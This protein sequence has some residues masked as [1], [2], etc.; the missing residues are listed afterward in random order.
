MTQEFRER[1]IMESVIETFDEESHEEVMNEAQH[2][3]D[4][5]EAPINY[6]ILNFKKEK[7]RNEIRIN[8]HV[9]ATVPNRRKRDFH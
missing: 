9:N 3:L 8:N 5:E 7:P 6:F 4:A 2:L 1:D